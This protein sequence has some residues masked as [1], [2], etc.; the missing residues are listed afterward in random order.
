MILFLKPY[1]FKISI[2]FLTNTCPIISTT[3]KKPRIT[4]YSYII[5][6]N[7]LTTNSP[8]IANASDFP[9]LKMQDSPQFFFVPH[10]L[11]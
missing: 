2:R 1:A 9:L 3:L 5:T 7:I 4:C 11:S 8:Q 10:H 6:L